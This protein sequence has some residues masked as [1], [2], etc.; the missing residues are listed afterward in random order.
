M[1]EKT[2]IQKILKNQ[3]KTVY[4]L[5]KETHIPETTL[6]PI[7][8]GQRKPLFETMMKIADGLHVSL[9]ELR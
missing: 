8:S 7:V 1:K 2:E 9:D 6:Y 5:A 3:R 4:W